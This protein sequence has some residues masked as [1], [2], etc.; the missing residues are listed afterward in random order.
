[1]SITGV[2]DAQ[3]GA[4]AMKGGLAISDLLTAMCVTSA[5][6]ALEHHTPER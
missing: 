5:I 2:S 1:M 4:A 6:T 3:P